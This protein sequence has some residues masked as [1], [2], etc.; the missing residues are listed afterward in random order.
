MR[1]IEKIII[2]CADT[3]ASMDVGAN[4]IRQWHLDRGWSDIGYHY[5]IRR[6]GV[7]ETG[8]DLDDDGDVD[9]HVGAHALGHNAHSLG[10]CL[11][12]GKGNDGQPDCNF[13][14]AQWESLGKLVSDLEARYPGA[15]VIGHR[16][17]SDKAC[18]TFN[19]GAWWYG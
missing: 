17:V 13:T 14:L 15:D 4:E 19:A 18:P 1:G 6:N 8:R 3:Y 12:G 7:I 2:H 5:V 11:V 10:I 16:D 9:E